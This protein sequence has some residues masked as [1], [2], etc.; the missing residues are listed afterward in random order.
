MAEKAPQRA[1]EPMERA[2]ADEL[3]ASRRRIILAH[4]RVRKQVAGRLHSNVHS[5]LIVSEKC[6]KDLENLL[7]DVP[8]ETLEHLRY[9]RTVLRQVIDH[10]MTSITRELYTTILNVGLPG[11]LKSLVDRYGGIFATNIE[12]DSHLAPMKQSTLFRLDEILCLALYRIAEEALEN[13]ARHALPAEAAVSLGFSSDHQICLS[14][15]DNGR[16]C[17]TAALKPGN[18]VLSMRDY[19]EALGGRLE[20]ESATGKGTKVSVWLPITGESP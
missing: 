15:E 2:R 12:I 18:G 6:L 8:Q 3:R 4:E 17:N 5:R 19:A 16:G 10:D 9:A 20:M 11:A 7:S 1:Q 13:V 14:L